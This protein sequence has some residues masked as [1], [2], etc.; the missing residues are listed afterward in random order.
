LARFTDPKEVGL[1]NCCGR[2]KR[3]KSMHRQGERDCREGERRREQN[4][5]VVQGR[6]SQGEETQPLAWNAGQRYG[7]PAVQCNWQE[8]KDAGRTWRPGLLCT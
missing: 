8:L 6:A 7:V 3:K 2:R 5:W 1:G 4:V